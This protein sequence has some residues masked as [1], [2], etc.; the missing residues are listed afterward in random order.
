M[1][2]G[3]LTERRNVAKKKPPRKEAPP[4]EDVPMGRI[5]LQAPQA[6]IDKL[7]AAAEALGL[8]RGAY[9]RL[10]CNRLMAANGS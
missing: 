3:V 6:W 5:E 10:A 8:S 1:T 9:I 4:A 7:D 2:T